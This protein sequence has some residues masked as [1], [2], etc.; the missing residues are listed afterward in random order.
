MNKFKIKKKIIYIG[1]H[2]TLWKKSQK[3]F[4]F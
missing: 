4:N 3:I 2:I 1:G